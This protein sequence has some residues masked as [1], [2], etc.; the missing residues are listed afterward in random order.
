MNS[1][2]GESNYMTKNKSRFSSVSSD[3]KDTLPLYKQIQEIIDT[4]KKD[5][6][7][8]YH[9]LNSLKQGKFIYK[10]DRQYLDECLSEHQSK[11]KIPYSTKLDSSYALTETRIPETIVSQS[12]VQTNQIQTS[13]EFRE[14]DVQNPTGDDI[15]AIMNSIE[16]LSNKIEDLRR[17]Y[18]NGASIF[19]NRDQ[20]MT[21]HIH[22]LNA[23]FEDAKSMYEKNGVALQDEIKLLKSEISSLKSTISSDK[24]SLYDKPFSNSQL[25][26]NIESQFEKTEYDESMADFTKII[27]SKIDSTQSYLDSLNSEIDK[28]FKNYN[29]LNAQ[30]QSTKTQLESVKSEYLEKEESAKKQIEKLNQEIEFMKST[31]PVEVKQP[32][33]GKSESPLFDSKVKNEQLETLKKEYEDKLSQKKE[34]DEYIENQLPA[35]T[36][37]INQL[38]EE[39]ARVSAELEKAK[40]ELNTLR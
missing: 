17:E 38:N 28:I 25:T 27:K 6:G 12:T 2:P 23:R 4:G 30:L 37:Q 26:K 32:I 40:S 11:K 33:T 39:Y 20:T 31:K 36:N 3:T 9:I 15:S 35:V 14:I 10:S 19:E 29:S 18:E 13:S 5:T 22:S 7:R 1:K 21:S 34:I 8:L 16:Q 24:V